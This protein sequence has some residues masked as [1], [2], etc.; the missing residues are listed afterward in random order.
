LRWVDPASHVTGDPE[1]LCCFGYVGL[2]REHSVF[3]TGDAINEP[4]LADRP[5]F[6]R[7]RANLQRYRQ[8]SPIAETSAIK[9]RDQD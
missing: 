7:A 5:I 1:S 9:S 6:L 2:V 8:N 3:S 4:I